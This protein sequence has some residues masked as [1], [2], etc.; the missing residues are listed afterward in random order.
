[1]AIKQRGE[2]WHY[3]FM[4]DGQRYRGSTKESV[5]S[6][7]KT[8]ESLLIADIRNN[9]GNVS[10]RR[11]PELRD[12]A[13]RFLHFVDAQTV[14]GQLDPD[15]KRYYNYGWKMLE[16]T[17]LANMRID[18]IGTSDAAIIFFP[19][20]P[21][22]TNQAFRTLRRMLHLA[23]E[24]NVL[25]A[26]PKIKTLQ[27]HGRKALI[28]SSTEAL[29]LEHA[30]QPFADILV[31]MMDSGMRPEEVMRMRKEHILWDRAVVLVPYGKSFKSTRYVPLSERMR[32]LLQNRQHNESPWVFPSPE[33]K[34]GH[35]TTIAKQWTETVKVANLT[36][37]KRKLPP[38][39]TSLKLYCARHTFA[40]DMLAE[41]MSLPAVRD[42]MG[43][44]DVRTTMKYLHPDTTQSAQMVNHRNRF[45]SL[46]LLEAAS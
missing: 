33:A 27:E 16:G 39:T 12:F 28:D 21:S 42:L 43:H 4:I 5:K 25:R 45:K 31:I 14:S 38:I 13:Q 29:L 34:D 24:W 35:R 11:A 3:E 41:G 7:A 26:A 18:Q 2:Y 20:S 32:M 46:N 10:M 17:I 6:R 15:T 30:P 37:A 19:G 44:E 9:S 36:A 40:T 8:F 22:Y 23:V 1:M